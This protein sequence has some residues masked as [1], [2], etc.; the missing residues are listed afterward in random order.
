MQ[1]EGVGSGHFFSWP[2]SC[3]SGGG[4]SRPAAVISARL[5]FPLT[6]TRTHQEVLLGRLL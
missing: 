4:V 1:H 6:Y 5:E 2:G 3:P